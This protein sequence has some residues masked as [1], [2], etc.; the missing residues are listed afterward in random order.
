MFDGIDF[1]KAIEIEEQLKL[2]LFI[3]YFFFNFFNFVGVINCRSFYL[4]K[5]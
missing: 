4:Q 1:S 5:F 3:F 2:K